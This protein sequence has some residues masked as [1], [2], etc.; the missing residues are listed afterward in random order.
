MT[1]VAKEH[2]EEAQDQTCH[3]S[4]GWCPTIRMHSISEWPEVLHNDMTTSGPELRDKSGPT[5]PLQPGSMLMSDAPVVMEGHA[6][7]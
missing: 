7:T 2:H 6:N 4:P 5:A 1:M 3:L